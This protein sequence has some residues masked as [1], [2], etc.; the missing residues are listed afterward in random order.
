M[1]KLGYLFHDNPGTIC[2]VVVI[3]DVVVAV[4]VEVTYLRDAKQLGF[5]T[6]SVF[7]SED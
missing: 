4:V 5:H 6:K 1:V 3:V 2:S 7:G